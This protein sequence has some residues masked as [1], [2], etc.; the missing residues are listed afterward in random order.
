[1]NVNE[2]LAD[3]SEAAEDAAPAPVEDD[4]DQHRR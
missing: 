4:R 2:P 1:M 3:A